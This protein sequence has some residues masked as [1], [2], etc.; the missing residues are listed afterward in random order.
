MEKEN[1]KAFKE[2]Q[3]LVFEFTESEK[4]VKYNLAT[5]ES[6]GKS[7]RVVKDI[8]AQLR[9]YKLLEII[10]SF[11]DEN[12]KAFLH[13]VDKQINQSTRWYGY[14]RVD[15][16]SNIG[17]FLKHVKEYSLF[18]QFF[19]CGI[20]QISENFSYEINDVPKRLLKIV[21]EDSKL[22]MSNKLVDS[23]K[24]NPN[25][26]LHIYNKVKSGTDFISLTEVEIF[27]LLQELHYENVEKGLTCSPRFSRWRSE[28]QFFW[29]NIVQFGYTPIGL[30]NYLDRLSTFEALPLTEKTIREIGDYAL[31]MNTISNKFEKYPKNF[32]TV[33]RIASRNYHRLKKD[34][35]EE[36]FKKRIDTSL[37]W[38]TDDYVFIYPKSTQEIKDESVQQ[39]NCVSSYIERVM[40]NKC[41]IIFMREK[42]KKDK[43]LVTI[44]IRN[45]KVVQA[46]RHYNYE[47]TEEQQEELDKYKKRLERV[48]KNEK[49][50]A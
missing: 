18:E 13:F 41:H 27:P 49:K 16:I 25:L 3:F 14:R 10:D 29:Q 40:D 1:L 36:L 46:L 32:L 43:S 9:G 34:F 30:L 33:H 6:I 15:K 22:K 26:F 38:E 20:H 44:E 37:E 35:P 42:K 45:N 8:C 5:G 28:T 50:C 19:A 2:K 24:H 12:Y 31:M 4:T 17:S 11:T 48:F 47:L 39:N 7:G 23:Y 21:R